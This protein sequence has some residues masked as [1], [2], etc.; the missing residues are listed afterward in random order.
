MNGDFYGLPTRTLENEHLRLEYLAEAGPRLVRL[1]LSGS[2]KNLLAELPDLSADTPEGRY[3]F[4][5]GHRLW[6][7]PEVFPRTYYPDNEGLQVDQ[8]PDGV[9]LTQPVESTTRIRK[10]IEI[11]LL[12]DQPGLSLRHM[13]ENTGQSPAEFA[14]WAITQLPLGGTAIL[15]QQVGSLDYAGLLPNRSLVLWPYTRWSDPRLELHDDYILIHGHDHIPPCKVGYP[16]RA[17]WAAYFRPPV[18][19]LKRFEP[20]SDQ[21]YPDFGSSVECYVND[22]FLELETL[23]PLTEISP[24][25]T[26][27][28]LETWSLF[29]LEAAGEGIEAIREAVQTIGLA[30]E[31]GDL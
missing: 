30:P 1:T 12:P 16:N 25:E 18:F 6:H 26:V 28:H 21:L 3:Y 29:E 31:D 7:S 15:P 2:D 24:G 22:R 5:G 23:G 4:R 19:F 8:I 11:T 9:R 10:M 13:L 14:P 20:V 17:G 27:D